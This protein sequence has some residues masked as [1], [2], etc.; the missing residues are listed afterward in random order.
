MVRRFSVPKLPRQVQRE[1]RCSQKLASP[2]GAIPA[3]EA[4]PGPGVKWTDGG[5][6]VR[7]E[8]RRDL[9]FPGMWRSLGALIKAPGP[10]AR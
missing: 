3:G 2:G 9:P 8:T 1:F 7:D 10:W 6:T 5:L 4:K